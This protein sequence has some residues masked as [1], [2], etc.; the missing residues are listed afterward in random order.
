M[1]ERGAVNLEDVFII[2]R[3][4]LAVESCE[5]GCDLGTQGTAWEDRDWKELPSKSSA[6]SLAMEHVVGETLFTVMEVYEAGSQI[7]RGCVEVG[8]LAHCVSHVRENVELY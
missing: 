2:N 4:D 7:R 3:F 8:Q 5:F 1:K 6:T